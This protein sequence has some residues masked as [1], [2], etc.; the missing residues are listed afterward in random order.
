MP[1][2]NLWKV[3]ENRLKLITPLRCHLSQITAIEI[4][5]SEWALIASGHDD[6]CISIF[7]TKPLC[8]IRTLTAPRK[9][10]VTMLRMSASNGDILVVQDRLVTL[11]TVNGELI[12]SVEL[13]NSVVDA[14]FT[15]FV[16]G[17]NQNF[18]F[19][20]CSDNRIFMLDTGDMNIVSEVRIVRRQ[21]LSI[22]VYKDDPGIAITHADGWISS[23]KLR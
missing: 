2:V 21:P 5:P 8:F 14:R 20:L 12:C 7:S 23:L 9:A 6:G 1:V 16:E 15:E 19:L 17:T 4:F 10:P 13:E 3:E 18:M 11:W 22:H